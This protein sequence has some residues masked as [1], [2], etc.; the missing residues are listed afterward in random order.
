[1]FVGG[2]PS[3][4]TEDA[5][6]ALFSEFGT[7]RS[8]HLPS[9]DFTRKNRRIGWIEM[10]GNEARAAIAGLNGKS[11]GDHGKPMKVCFE[12]IRSAGKKRRR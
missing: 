2:I 10:E 9:D 3:D 5:V 8:I 6:R 7:V 1:M 4:T 12:D 11:F